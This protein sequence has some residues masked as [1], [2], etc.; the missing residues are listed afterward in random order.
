MR[1]MNYSERLAFQTAIFSFTELIVACGTSSFEKSDEF[2]S[3]VALES[4]T[5]E[6]KNLFPTRPFLPHS[7]SYL[8][9]SGDRDP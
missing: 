5:I 4:G 6:D 8:L 9:L 2:D 1:D 3:A 7:R